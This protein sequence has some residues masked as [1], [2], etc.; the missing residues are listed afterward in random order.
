MGFWGF[1]VIWG[2]PAS[3]PF[4]QESSSPS[5]LSPQ[6]WFVLA[7]QTKPKFDVARNL[8]IELNCRFYRGPQVALRVAPAS[9][10]G[11]TG[12]ETPCSAVSQPRAWSRR[13]R[14]V[15]QRPTAQAPDANWYECHLSGTLPFLQLAPAT[16]SLS[17]P[18]SAEPAQA[19]QNRF[20]L[21]LLRGLCG[22]APAS[23]TP[24]AATTWPFSQPITGYLREPPD[25]NRH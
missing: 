17:A 9:S 11:S 25:P 16:P 10:R 21:P 6:R 23:E 13:A 20:R 7:P 3:P 18:T 2:G 22:C 12:P 19:L 24:S 5:P 1:G 4:L 8:K 14:L 15:Q